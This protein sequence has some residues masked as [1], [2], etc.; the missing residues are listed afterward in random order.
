MAECI[1]ARGGGGRSDSGGG[2]PPVI[3]GYCQVVANVYD[4]DGN[5]FP[6]VLVCCKDGNTWYNYHSN[7]KG[8]ILFVT[9]SGSLNITAYNWSSE[10][11]FTWIDQI[12]PQTMN[13]DAPVTTSKYCSINFNTFKSNRTYYNA[14]QFNNIKFKSTNT[15]QIICGGAGGGGSGGY[16]YSYTSAA[17]GGGGA[18]NSGNITVDKNTIYPM[19]IGQGG[20]GSYNGNY[21]ASSGGSTSCAGIVAYGGEGGWGRTPGSGSVG[22]AGGGGNGGQPGTNR[23]GG[24]GGWG[25]AN[26]NGAAG[27]NPSGGRGAWVEDRVAY[28][29]SSGSYG[30]GGGGGYTSEIQNIPQGSHYYMGASGG[31]GLI[32]MNNFK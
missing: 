27:G 26:Y 7:D 31:N 3:Q 11:K 32:H 13:I 19:Y 8:Q 15:V 28:P 23:Y 4:G 5:P 25:G 22:N 30:G 1:I 20:S 17:G 10:N 16:K 29:P 2:L 18:L 21:K 6:D 12:A 9:N 24:G 14:V